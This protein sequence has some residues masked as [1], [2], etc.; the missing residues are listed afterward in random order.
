MNAS[1]QV[2]ALFESLFYSAR[3]G[4]DPFPGLPLIVTEKPG[5]IL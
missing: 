2:I 3:P 1:D 4:T 5:D